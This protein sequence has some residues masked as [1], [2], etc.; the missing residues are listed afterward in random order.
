MKQFTITKKVA[1]HGKQAIIVVPRILEDEL[2]PGTIV[3][4]T[5]DV[6]K[7]VEDE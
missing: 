1:K 4:I 3:K 5:M 7:E 2:K 6:L